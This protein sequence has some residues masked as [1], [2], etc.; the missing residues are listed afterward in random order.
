MTA[1]EQQYTAQAGLANTVQE[2]NAFEAKALAERQKREDLL[3]Q[4]QIK[5]AQA[6]LSAGLTNHNQ[7]DIDTALGDLAAATQNY[8]QLAQTRA[9]ENAAQAKSHQGPVANYLDSL[10]DIK[11]EI[12]NIEVQGLQ[13]LTDGITQAIE[14]TKSLGAAFHDVANQ[15]ISD[16]LR[17]AVQKAITAP[18][19]NALFGT[20][21]VAALFGIPGFASGTDFAPGGT[22]VVGE[23]GPELVNLPRGSQVLPNSVLRNAVG[24]VS[25]GGAGMVYAPTFQI[26]ANNG[27]VVSELQQ[28]IL[29]VSTHAAAQAY[30]LA[31]K[32]IPVQMA[33][34]GG[35]QLPR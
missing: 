18:L 20:T 7:H 23:N 21:G 3:A 10:K 29:A 35:R 31:R 22:A 34:Q 32:T 14:G 25:G 1:L 11:T 13:G 27:L 4:D 24:A 2:R 8:N 12:Q 5:R 28:H 15:I 16:L 26:S 19:A 33:K 30:D 17:I 6:A 9:Q